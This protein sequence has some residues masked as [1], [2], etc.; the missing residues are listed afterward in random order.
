MKSIFKSVFIV[1]AFAGMVSGCANSDEYDNPNT[2]IQT[3]ELTPT[4]TVAQIISETNSTVTQYTTDD[5]I[6]AYVTSSDEGSNFYNSISFQTIPTDGSNPV[7]F[8]VPVTMKYFVKGF[9]PGRKVYIKLNGL[10]RAIVD[11]SMQIGELYQPNPTDAPAVGRIGESRWQNY[12]FPSATHVDE[13]TFARPLTL[14]QAAT[15]V[16]LNTLVDLQGVQFSDGSLG[17]TYYDVDSGGGATN[18][19]LSSTTGGTTRFFRVSSFAEF[20]TKMIPSGSGTIRGVMTKY[21]S[22]YQFLS[23]VESDVRLN[24]VR[25]DVA[26]PVVG[27]ALVNSGSFTENFESYSAG[28]ATTGQFNFPKYINDPV[29]GDKFWRC[30]TASSNKYIEMTSFSTNQTVRTM[31]IVPV[32]MGAASTFAFKTKASFYNG[33][34]LKIYYS[35]DYTPGADVSTATLVNITSNFTI[36]DGSSTSFTPSGT[37][38]IPAALTGNGYFFFEYSGTAIGTPVITTNMDIDDIVVN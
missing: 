3:Y 33:N 13:D 27:N 18:H 2:S 37:Y 20:A 6:E 32:D 24:N 31:F 12:L 26:P 34:T 19:D 21:G 28:S 9:T 7:G 15:D 25:V 23:R 1:A 22:D 38:N 10:Y 16:N 8:S 4:K 5:V 17:R 14:A 36:N 11:G 29:V 35:T 30:R